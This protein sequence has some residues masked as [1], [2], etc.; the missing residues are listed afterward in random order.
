MARAS[1]TEKEECSYSKFLNKPIDRAPTFPCY[2]FFDME[3]VADEHVGHEDLITRRSHHGSLFECHRFFF[4]TRRHQ[5][6]HEMSL[7]THFPSW[8]VGSLVP[9]RRV[10]HGRLVGLPSSADSFDG[11]DV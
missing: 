1:K 7:V 6:L 4:M 11:G 2:R 3:G 10:H 8:S 5:N 9:E